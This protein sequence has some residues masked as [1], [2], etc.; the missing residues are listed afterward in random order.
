ML[1]IK[2]ISIS[3][4]TLRLLLNIRIIISS[5]NRNYYK[6]NNFVNYFSK[7]LNNKYHSRM[8]IGF[9]LYILRTL[10]KIYATC[11]QIAHFFMLMIKI[12][13]SL[14]DRSPLFQFYILFKF[15]LYTKDLASLRKSCY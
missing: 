11:T 12:C 14:Y 13:T 3:K 4:K 10:S 6:N 7:N 9:Y 1:A 15:F 2:Y 5:K 8:T